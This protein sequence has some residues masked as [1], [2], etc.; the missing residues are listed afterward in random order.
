MFARLYWIKCVHRG[1]RVALE[2]F[3]KVLSQT[4]KVSL[5]YLDVCSIKDERRTPG[6]RVLRKKIFKS[7]CSFWNLVELFLSK[8]NELSISDNRKNSSHRWRTLA[9]GE[10]ASLGLISTNKSAGWECAFGWLRPQT[11]SLSKHTECF[12]FKKKKKE[13]NKK[14]KIS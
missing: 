1:V 2:T 5:Y 7:L 4:C 9:R 13:C 12:E 3:F 10:G 11:S 14:L 6:Y 8:S